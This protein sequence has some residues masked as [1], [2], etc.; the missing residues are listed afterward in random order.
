MPMPLPY[1]ALIAQLPLA[2]AGQLLIVMGL[3]FAIITLIASTYR[4]HNILQFSD[5]D[6]IT[7]ENCNDFF[8]IQ[9][10]RYLSKI[11]RQTA[12]FGVIIVEFK[13]EAS[14]RRRTQEKL[15]GE[16]KKFIREPT[17][18]VCLY[19]ADCVA[20]I[21]DT[22]ES[23][24]PVVGRRIAADLKTAVSTLPD[25]TAFRIGVSAFPMH[26]GTTRQMIDAATEAMEHVD[27]EENLPIGMA[28]L[29]EQEEKPLPDELGELSR[30]DK[31][32]SLDPLTG[33]LSPV[34]VGSY[35]RK[36][37]A[38]IRH[39]KKPVALL[40]VGV[41]G[42]DHLI[43]LHGEEAADAV[44]ASVSGVLQRL[45][46]E[47]D[48]IGRYHRDDFMILA[49]CSLKQGE[50]MALRLHEAVQKETFISDGRRIKALISVGIAGHPE[51]GRNLSDLFG[52]AYRALEVVRGWNTNSCLTYDPAQHNKR[53]LKNGSSS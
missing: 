23:R 45:T 16:L 22:E 3:A 2:Q 24:V 30:Q 49:A 7:V 38:E 1:P 28:P 31:H 27:F 42:I 41:T 12:G 11:N 29:P 18:R 48:L 9:V 35:M 47:S 46:R 53:R 5:K 33:V 6:L 51:H 34:V 26:G 14:D 44:L 50:E 37:F 25:I 21:I 43:M 17:D 39:K 13:T 15:L 52:G 40:C 19:R 32:S 4:F 10:A 36:Y 20:A 8:F